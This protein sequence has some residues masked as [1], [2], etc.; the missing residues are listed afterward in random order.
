MI[1]NLSD[2]NEQLDLYFNHLNEENI[3]NENS[4]NIVFNV[5]Q[6]TI[7]K[8]KKNIHYYY[9]WTEE[10][11]DK[12]LVKITIDAS[13]NKLNQFILE[14]M[15]K[16]IKDRVKLFYRN[17]K[18]YLIIIETMTNYN[19]NEIIDVFCDLIVFCEENKVAC[20]IFHY[21]TNTRVQIFV[22]SYWVK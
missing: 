4:K 15:N 3:Q 9:R 22:N 2:L 13:D 6:T 21:N 5:D 14:E 12:S 11:D 20:K 17:N 16:L 10:R 18:D 7:E 8:F 19:E 1:N